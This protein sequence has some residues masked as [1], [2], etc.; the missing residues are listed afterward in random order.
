MK[1]FSILLVSVIVLLIATLFFVMRRD[2]TET[3]SPPKPLTAEEIACYEYLKKEMADFEYWVGDKHPSEVTMVEFQYNYRITG[4]ELSILKPLSNLEEL[5]CHNAHQLN[6][7]FTVCLKYL[8]K[9]KTLILSATEVTP[10]A[11]P[12]IVKLK[13]LET[14]RII[15]KYSRVE[16]TKQWKPEDIFT[17]SSL[18]MLTECGQLKHLYIGEPCSISDAGLEQLKKLPHLEYFGITTDKVTPSGVEFL[19]TLPHIKEI[20]IS[21]PAAKRSEGFSMIVNG[22]QR[23]QYSPPKAEETP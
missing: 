7:S 2:N 23:I 3:A 6:D 16:D 5:N 19:K 11:L 15:R 14:L 9:L 20:T 4:A 1:K 18:E 22:E 13:H 10:G 12:E 17:D 21:A 8:P